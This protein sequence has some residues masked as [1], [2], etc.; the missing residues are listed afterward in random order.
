MARS[1]MTCCDVSQ[2]AD[3]RSIAAETMASN[4]GCASEVVTT[5]SDA[6]A[7]L[8]AGALAPCSAGEDI[9]ATSNRAKVASGENCLK[10]KASQR[11]VCCAAQTPPSAKSS[12]I[13]QVALWYVA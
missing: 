2:V 12:G 11:S 7:D 8:A 9:A 6:F 10:P 1:M 4:C 3:Q 5:S 13:V